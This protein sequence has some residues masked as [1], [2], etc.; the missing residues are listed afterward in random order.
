MV[1]RQITIR[2]Q[3]IV[4]L[5]KIVSFNKNKQPAWMK[6]DLAAALFLANSE[7]TNVYE[8]LKYTGLIDVNN[9]GI[10]YQALYEFLLYGLKHTFPAVIGSEAKGI[11]TSINALPGSGIKSPNYVWPDYEG[12]QRGY[13]ITPLYPEISSAAKEDTMLHQLLAACDVLRIGQVREVNFARNWLKKELLN[14]D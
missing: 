13:A 11:I 1:S 14:K 8:R 4:A 6:K 2:P 12:K 10:Q 3:D 9:N 7:I 5:L